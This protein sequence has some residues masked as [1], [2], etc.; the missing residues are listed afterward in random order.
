MIAAGSA[1][2]IGMLGALGVLVV[3]IATALAWELRL[4]LMLVF[5]AVL[6]AAALATPVAWLEARGWPRLAAV[7]SFYAGL[8]LVLAGV[9]FL[10]VP[11]LVEE[12]SDLVQNLPELLDEAEEAVTDTL[13][14]L[15][16]ADAVDRAFE[17]IGGEGMRPDADTLLAGP[18][19][20]AEGL[21]NV[22]V[23]LVLSIFLLLERDR[24]RGW[25]L[26]FFDPDQRAAVRDLSAGA[27]TKLGAYVRGQL[28]IMLVVGVGATI[29]M[30]VLGVPFALPLGVLAFLVEAIPI[31]GPWIAGVPIVLVALLESPLT[32]LFIGIWFVAL[33]QVESYIL[34]PVVQGH[35]VHLSPFVV[36]VSVLAGATIAGVMGAI[37]AV[38]LVAVADL[39]VNEVILPLRRGDAPLAEEPS[40]A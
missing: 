22:A 1:F 32:A 2:R 11:P 34:Q 28:L 31:A 3:V 21:L 9:L 19:L 5:L 33:Q 24:I 23:V 25:V 38:P 37:I 35:V 14:G 17:V 13:G 16:G 20:I 39:L 12:A 4:L 29:G 15:L 27:A 10:V 8:V 30:L 7:L 6:I 26:R 18:L 36:M 40:T